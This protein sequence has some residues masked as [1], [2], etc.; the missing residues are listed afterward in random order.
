MQR[1]LLWINLIHI[2]VLISA[3]QMYH[4]HYNTLKAKRRCKQF[5]AYFVMAIEKGWPD[6][7]GRMGMYLFLNAAIDACDAYLAKL[8]STGVVPTKDEIEPLVANIGG[9]SPRNA[10]NSRY[11]IRKM[12]YPP[13]KSRRKPLTFEEKVAAYR[14][15]AIWR[16][17]SK[18]VLS[19]EAPRSA[20]N[21]AL[22]WVYRN[23]V[24]DVTHQL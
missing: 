23:G 19:Q 14:D 10:N 5:L 17:D 21:T 11:A 18:T 7:E 9:G 20:G 24:P 22:H 8:I 13:A 3:S 6:G 1:P 4:H 16:G 15:P 2:F 12:Q